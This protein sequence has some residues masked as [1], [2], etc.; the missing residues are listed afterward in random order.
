MWRV[1]VLWPLGCCENR[2]YRPTVCWYSTRCSRDMINDTTFCRHITAKQMCLS[3]FCDSAIHHTKNCICFK[4]FEWREPLSVSFTATVRVVELISTKATR[5]FV[6]EPTKGKN[7]SDISNT[8]Q[9]QHQIN[10]NK[11]EFIQSKLPIS[12]VTTT[13]IRV[14]TIIIIKWIRICNRLA[15]ES[16]NFV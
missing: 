14:A 10:Q 1:R 7:E 4:R 5:R 11:F 3:L 16:G 8:I 9:K 15:Y 6:F 13:M 2:L 12:W